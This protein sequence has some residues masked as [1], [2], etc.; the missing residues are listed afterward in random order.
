MRMS[1]D[2]C[3]LADGGKVAED[4]HGT[5]EAAKKSMMVLVTKNTL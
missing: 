4:V 3:F 2:Y 5:S 1:M